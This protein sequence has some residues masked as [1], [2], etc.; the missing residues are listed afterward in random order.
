MNTRLCLTGCLFCLLY[1]GLIQA[2]QAAGYATINAATNVY[3][4]SDP[5]ATVV[6]TLGVGENIIPVA[7]G[8]QARGWLYATYHAIAYGSVPTPGTRV[9]KNGWFR[10]RDLIRPEKMPLLVPLR[11]KAWKPTYLCS[12]MTTPEGVRYTQEFEFSS[13]G[14]IQSWVSAVAPDGRS[15]QLTQHGRAFLASNLLK[16]VYADDATHKTDE[17]YFG[18]KPPEGRIYDLASPLEHQVYKISL[19]QIAGKQRVGDSADAKTRC[20]HRPR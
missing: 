18:Y 20:V 15:K 8:P 11:N 6:A 9:E 16:L 10:T 3:S 13:N 5:K 4:S 17:I 19:F 7:N 12:M 14:N 1:A 2:S